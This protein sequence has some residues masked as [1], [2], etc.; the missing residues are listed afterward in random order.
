MGWIPA[1]RSCAKTGSS[2]PR[3]VDKA[4]RAGA[5][6][7]SRG[8]AG[9]GPCLPDQTASADETAAQVGVSSFHSGGTDLT[10]T[11]HVSVFLSLSS[12]VLSSWLCFPLTCLPA[13]GLVWG[14]MHRRHL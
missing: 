3:R 5:R 9:P 12:C 1:F 14:V 13:Q 6:C 4:A 7:S 11:C 2:T 10:Q 8:D